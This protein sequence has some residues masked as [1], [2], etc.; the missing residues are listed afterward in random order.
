MGGR[1]HQIAGN[2][3]TLRNSRW[4]MVKSECLGLDLSEGGVQPSPSSF[5]IPDRFAIGDRGV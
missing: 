4:L 3:T 2:S 5:N 1:A